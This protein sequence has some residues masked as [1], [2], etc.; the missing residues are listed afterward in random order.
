MYQGDPR[1]SDVE[2]RL[3]S[4]TPASSSPVSLEMPK[5]STL[6]SEEPSARWVRKRFAG[7]RSR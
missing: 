4:G 7:L 6:T 3:P 1:I 2:V 5:S